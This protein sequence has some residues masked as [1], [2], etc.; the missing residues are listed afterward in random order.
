MKHL[1]NLGHSILMGNEFAALELLARKGD[2]TSRQFRQTAAID[3]GAA[4]VVS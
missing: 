1:S 3:E 2:D 4:G